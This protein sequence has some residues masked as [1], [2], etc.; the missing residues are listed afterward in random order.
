VSDNTEEQIRRL[1]AQYIQSHDRE[2]PDAVVACFTED[3]RLSVPSGARPQGR[4]AV[5]EF[6]VE[7][8]TR[9]RATRRVMKHLY[10]NTHIQL[11][12]DT[13]KVVSDWVAYESVAGG[14]W[15][16]NMIGQS[17]DR[18]VLQGGTWLLAER[19]NVDIRRGPDP[20][21]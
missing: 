4:H 10:A 11:D 3:A 9:R 21:A 17:I 8:Y 16:I 18:V 19:R 6:M 5:R 13:A 7:Q 1:L 14:P 2:D 20:S 12:G 15:A